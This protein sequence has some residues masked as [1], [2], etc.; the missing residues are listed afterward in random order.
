MSTINDTDQ[1]LVQRGSTSHKQ[2]A[3][4]LMSTIQDTDLMLI[5]RG[6]ESFKVTCEDVKD[7]L[8]GGGTPVLTISKGEITPSSNV[9]EGDTLTG[10]A[11]VAG[12]VDPTV[13]YHRWYV[14]GV[15]EPAETTNTFR[16]KEGSI[17]YKLCVTDPNNTSEVCGELSDAVVATAASQPTATMHGLRFDKDRG[18]LMARNLG[19]ESVNSTLS[20]WVKP[21]S[22]NEFNMLFDSG[23]TTNLNYVLNYVGGTLYSRPKGSSP[24]TASATLSQNS[25]NHV[26]VSRSDQDI[27]FYLDGVNVGSGT[28]DTAG[29][30]YFT[31]SNSVALSGIA[32]SANNALLN[33]YFSDV[34][35]VD[36]QALPPETFG[37]SFDGKWGPLDSSKVKENIGYKESPADTVPNYAEKWSSGSVTGGFQNPV[38]NLFDGDLSTGTWADSP[39]GF[40]LIFPSAI[41]VSNSITFVGGSNE[42]NYLAIVD[43]NEIPFT[44][45]D[46][47]TN[48]YQQQ[49]TVSVS[50]SFTA[51]KSTNQ[52]GELHG[53]K[54]DRRLL[55]DGP[56]DNSQVWSDLITHTSEP[57][58]PFS[59]G[60]DGNLATWTEGPLGEEWSIDLSDQGFTGELYIASHSN[61]NTREY[62]YNGGSWTAPS[63]LDDWELLDSDVTGKNILIEFKTNDGGAGYQLNGIKA[64]GKVLID[65]A[66]AWNTSQV[67]SD[68]TKTGDNEVR[69]W[70]NAFSASSWTSIDSG[71][72]EAKIEMDNTVTCVQSLQL[73]QILGSGLYGCE[74]IFGTDSVET[75]TWPGT[76][77]GESNNF[78]DVPGVLYPF[79][80]N[81]IWLRQ[82][83]SGAGVDQGRTLANLKV[84]GKIL[85]DGRSFGDNGFFLPF[86]PAAE[87]I[88]ADDSGQGNNFVDSGFVTATVGAEYGFKAVTYAGNGGAQ[89]ISGLSFSPDLLWIK[90]R[91][92]DFSHQLH[93]S[94]RGAEVGLSANTVDGEYADNQAVT[95]F[96][97]NGWSMNNN[98]GSHN[99]SGQNYIAWCWDAGD[100]TVANTDG[101]ITS[102]VR[103]NPAVGFSIVSYKGT[104]SAA[105]VGHGLQAAPALVIIKK[106][107]SS[108][109]WVVGHEAASFTS[110]NY[111]VLNATDGA[112]TGNG[113]A[114]NYTAP[115]SSVVHIGSSTVLNSANDSFIA[116]CWAETP[117]VSKFG[118]YSGNGGTNSITVGFEPAYVL[119]K[120]TNSTEN[121]LIIDNQRDNRL[122]FAN[123]STGESSAAVLDFTGDGFTLTQG[124]GASNASGGNYIYA[125]FA[126]SNQPAPD[127]VLDTPMKNYAVLNLNSGNSTISNGALEYATPDGGGG[128]LISSIEMA[129]DSGNYYFEAI[130]KGPQNSELGAYDASTN[131]SSTGVTHVFGPNLTA[132]IVLDTS[133]P[134]LYYYEDGSLVD[135]TEFAAG[136]SYRFVGMNSGSGSVVNFGQQPFAY[137][138]EGASGL[139]QTWSEWT[140]LLLVARLEQD[141]ARISQLEQV[142]IAQSVPFE[143]DKVY[144][145]GTIVDFGGNLLEALVDGADITRSDIFRKRFGTVVD[146]IEWA[147]LEIKTREVTLPELEKPTTLPAP[148][149]TNRSVDLEGRK[150][151]RNADGT[152]RGD[153]PSTPDVNEAWEDG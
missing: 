31:G 25:W 123:L 149:P 105:T 122:I 117:G 38:E 91:G 57:F 21:T 41:D 34:Y 30:T 147:D 3:K 83:T 94:V 145:K 32:A 13:Y 20:V 139:Y 24:V 111:L 143:K 86:D 98:Y 118:S 35:F 140:S 136:A 1:F 22:N 116:Y 77:T 107:N 28:A 16:A 88:G 132:G 42:A 78:V 70:K 17:T 127:T 134:K 150:R 29:L 45:Q 110:D 39:A 121:W 48:G 65:G 19:Q 46:P 23:E 10:S 109:F 120:R 87:G 76:E 15:L 112:V 6:T 152:Y 92:S 37:K 12:N 113:I 79:T 53:V 33:G 103:A 138:V 27:T 144:P 18:T 9:E 148:T 81:T 54:A 80:F 63:N 128:V 52:N 96:D 93:D 7:Q 69:N 126:D 146:Q 73:S 130:T 56:A 51:I 36:G 151:A 101:S 124:G 97:A 55:I 11:T 43:G 74:V 71:Q 67:W 64:G 106:T 137:P 89:S 90:N 66:P 85:V 47:S 84:D 129:A 60:F 40:V 14:D 119:I 114:W 4:D 131:P 104:G 75:A 62:R 58:S 50:G 72:T 59:Q 115:T 61:S 102:Q 68:G 82:R 133:V 5:Q 125:A 99:G 8:G 142:I 100:T 135:Q 141:E 26:V 2:S 49:T 44:F 95:S 108:G 153:D